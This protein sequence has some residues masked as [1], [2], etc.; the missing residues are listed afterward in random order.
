MLADVEVTALLFAGALISVAPD[1]GVEMLTGVSANV[2]AAVMTALEFTMSTSLEEW[3]LFC[4]TTFVCW[5]AAV[6]DCHRDLQAS[7]PWY[8][9]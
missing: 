7:I 4:W 1:G 6:L 9:V 8:H 2:V 3:L 5:P